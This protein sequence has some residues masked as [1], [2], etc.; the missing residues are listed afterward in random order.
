MLGWRPVTLPLSTSFFLS[1]AVELSLR[2]PLPKRFSWKRRDEHVA[3][4]ASVGTFSWHPLGAST[5][6][7]GVVRMPPS[8]VESVESQSPWAARLS[9]RWAADK[10]MGAVTFNTTSAAVQVGISDLNG[11][12]YWWLR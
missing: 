6:E 3:F 10:V 9:G 1:S 11:I 5:L 4:G 2:Q 12:F 7:A 8:M